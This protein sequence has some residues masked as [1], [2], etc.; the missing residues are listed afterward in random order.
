MT[1]HAYSYA[2]LQYRHDVW[3]GEA[4]NAGVLLFSESARFLKLKT[5][6]GQGRLAQ[7]YPDLDHG[8]FREAVKALARR[9]DRIAAT[10]GLLLPS[11][12]ALEVGQK[13]LQLDD[14]S[15]AWGMTGS[16]VTLDPD[17]ALTNLF[18]RFVGRYD[19][20]IGREPRTDEMVFEAVRRKLELAELYGRVQPQVVR[21]KYASIHFKHTIENGALHVI[22]PVSFDSADAENMLDKAAKWAGRLQSIKELDGKV[23]PYFVTGRPTDHA[24]MEQ[25]DKMVALLLASP[26]RP[27]VM[28]EE[29]AGELVAKIEEQLH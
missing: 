22:Q 12:S 5:R 11:G 2:V 21:S 23:R 13:V 8:A 16:G 27:V 4:L 29:R 6:T 1:K 9:F 17:E 19:K 28:H 20:A 3:V 25:Y 15:L 24:L 10:S 7:A 26:L 18:G 14:S